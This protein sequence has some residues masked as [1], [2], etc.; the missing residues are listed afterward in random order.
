VTDGRGEPVHNFV[1]PYYVSPGVFRFHFT[2]YHSGCGGSAGATYNGNAFG[3]MYSYFSLLPGHVDDTK[4][5][6]ECRV[7]YDRD[8]QI[9]PIC[10]VVQ[11]DGWD[12]PIRRCQ[13]DTTGKVRCQFIRST[14]R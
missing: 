14:G 13:F 8:G 12:N 3:N 10:A 2:A 5:T 9:A 7:A 6:S 4:A 1:Q 11:R